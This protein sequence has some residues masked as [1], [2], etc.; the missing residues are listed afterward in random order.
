M[1]FLQYSSPYP[2][3]ASDHQRHNAKAM[4]EAGVS[5][6]IE[7]DDCNSENIIEYCK[8]LF[9]DPAKLD[10]M[11]LSCSRIA[12]KTATYDIVEQIKEVAKIQPQE[13]AQQAEDN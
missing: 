7:N 5:L 12:K 8:T 10:F 2:F 9:E 11:R 6:Y 1:V 4:H 13:P 3:A